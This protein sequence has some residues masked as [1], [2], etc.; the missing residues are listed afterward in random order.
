MTTAAPALHVV[1]S[2]RPTFYR[3]RPAGVDTG[4]PCVVEYVDDE[5]VERLPHV[6]VHSPTG[7]QW[8]YGGSGPADLALS[9]LCHVLGV[10]PIPGT[11]S[12]TPYFER[13]GEAFERAW[14][15]HQP[16]KWEVVA[17]FPMDEPWTLAREQVERFVERNSGG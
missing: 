17:R 13:Y 3:G 5:G 15:L 2:T 12:T 11:L 6:A 1:A 16:F 9:L 10:M 14:A 4:G 8:G 7:F